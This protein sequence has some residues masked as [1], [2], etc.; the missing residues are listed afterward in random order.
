M[1]KSGEL[2]PL[3]LKKAAKE[4]HIEKVNFDRALEKEKILQF[5]CVRVSDW[6]PWSVKNQETRDFKI[7]ID[8]SDPKLYLQFRHDPST[9]TLKFELVRAGESYK[10]GS[11]S[12][13]EQLASIID[14]LD[15]SF[16]GK[17]T[18][19]FRLQDKAFKEQVGTKDMLLL[20]TK[21][22]SK[23]DD[24]R[25]ELSAT[26]I[27]NVV[28]PKLIAWL[29]ADKNRA[30]AFVRMAYTYVTARSEISSPFVIAK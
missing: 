14:T 7:Y 9:P 16:S 23:F 1:I 12:S 8:K 27:T 24:E 13:I 19:M 6:K 2:L 18:T 5:G 15:A 10:M 3:S 4:V 11:I 21:N 17:I 22:R 28:N 29:K 20:K 26:L 25:T 30:D